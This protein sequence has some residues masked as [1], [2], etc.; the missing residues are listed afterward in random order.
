MRCG[1]G[2][3]LMQGSNDALVQQYRPLVRWV[4]R[5]LKRRMPRAALEDL[6]QAGFMGLI[7]AAPRYRAENGASFETYIGWR[8]RGSMVDSL[9]EGDWTP[10]SVAKATREIAQAI[11]EIEVAEQRP[12]REIEI[13]ERLRLSLADY[14][15]VLGDVRG[16][17]VLNLDE[18]PG[19]MDI[20]SCSQPEEAAFKAKLGAAIAAL[21][22]RER[23]I[24]ERTFFDGAML[25]EIGSELGVTESRTCQLRG[26]AVS[27][28]RATLEGGGLRGRL[29]V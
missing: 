2:G 18:A 12:A 14:R 27:R 15:K 1:R 19:A 22:E 13:A 11:R 29:W 6:E 28:L 16:C 20:P 9:R 21:P 17:Y 3:A 24:V 25:V 8:I 23:L 26:Q 10:R 5:G 7:E 4:A